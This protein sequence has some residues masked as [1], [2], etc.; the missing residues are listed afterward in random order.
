MKPFERMNSCQ[1]SVHCPT[2]VTFIAF[3]QYE[4]SDI[5][6][7]Y[8]Y[9][10]FNKLVNSVPT[11]NRVESYFHAGFDSFFAGYFWKY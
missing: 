11:D 4:L 1:I 2:T 9:A 5:V 3:R 8:L 6:R 10:T 7:D